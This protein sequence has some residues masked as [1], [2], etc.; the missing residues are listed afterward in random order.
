VQIQDRAQAIA[1]TIMQA[2]PQDVVLIA[3]KG[4]EDSQ[5]IQGRKLPFS[6]AAQ[7]QAAL[8]ARA[9]AQVRA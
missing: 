6:D 2:K 7:A 4:H 5:E 1:Y 3:G 9:K 8:V